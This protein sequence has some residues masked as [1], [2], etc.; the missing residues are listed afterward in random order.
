MSGL[1]RSFKRSM[2]KEHDAQ[3][4]AREF[5]RENPGDAYTLDPARATTIH[6]PP[7][8]KLRQQ[9][10]SKWP[11]GFWD[12]FY[13]AAS[14]YNRRRYQKAKEAY[15]AAYSLLSDYSALHTALLRTYRKLYK[16]AVDKK[17]WGEAHRELCE[18]FATLPADVSD[19]DR[20]QLNKVVEVLKKTNPDFSAQPLPLSKQSET[21]REELAARVEPAAGIGIAVQRDDTWERLKGERALR[22]QE[23]QVTSNGFVAVHRVYDEQASGYN[24]CRIRT[25]SS[26]G[27]IAS[28]EDWSQSFYR[29]KICPAGEYLL[30]FSDGLKM[31][32]WTL[33]RERLAERNIIREAENNKYHVKCID[34]SKNA[35]HCLFTSIT[36]AYLLDQRLRTVRVWVM[37]P[38]KSYEVRRGSQDTGNGQIERALATLELTGHPTQEEIK[39]QFRRLVLR[40]H[41]DRNPGDAAAQE[42]TKEI[43][44]A[45]KMV[46][47]GDILAVLEGLGDKEYY[48]KILHETESEITGTGLAI[49][50]TISIS[51]SG[52]WIYASHLAPHAERIYLGCYSG[53]VYCV[54]FGGNVL[55]VYSTDAPIDGILERRGYVYL[56]THT[57]LYVLQGEKVGNHIDLREGGLECFT[58]WG[59]II[60]KGPSLILCSD[61]GAWLGTVYFPKEPREV[62]PTL[63][64][65]VAYTTKERFRVLLSGPFTARPDDS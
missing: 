65:L 52:D 13:A 3:P 57:S 35:R 61:G 36:R 31:S 9:E 48:Y 60:K 18:L 63:T 54:D 64:G 28:Q 39:A 8:F 25:Y 38:P 24:S 1:A 7:S 19:T 14:H 20:R 11:D 41:P 62:I 34:L 21:K 43:I 55:K 47:E 2:D 5:P 46:S 29:L 27:E 6:L 45:Y 37:P 53:T 22:W 42:R 12:R 56:W 16:A 59:F 26:E 44:A 15:M 10:T 50:L 33:S 17:R 58:E 40:Y 51:G 32:L 49:K 23:R 30:G 4:I